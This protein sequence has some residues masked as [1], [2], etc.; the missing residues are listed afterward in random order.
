MLNVQKKYRK[1]DTV[2]EKY[3]TARECL[4]NFEKMGI[5]LTESTFSKYKKRGMFKRY[6]V[7]GKKT[8]M[9]IWREVIECYFKAKIDYTEEDVEIRNRYYRQKEKDRKIEEYLKEICS[10]EELELSMF[11]I[12]N[13]Y[14]DAQNNLKEMR[15]RE[16]RG[17]KID[18]QEKELIE[19]EGAKTKED[20]V[21]EIEKEIY[22]DN[23]VYNSIRDLS[24]TLRRELA[25]KYSN[26]ESS[27]LEC[28]ILEIIANEIRFYRNPKEFVDS[29]GVGLITIKKP[30]SKTI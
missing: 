1:G 21:R 19:T 11:N 16:S 23:C 8:D 22:A 24:D 6:K 17:E 3:I 5:K 2:Q 13:L 12:D 27:S 28:D 18:D 20:Y 15:E 29:F 30:K 9:F 25:K 14:T 10:G 7:D 4:K 26:F